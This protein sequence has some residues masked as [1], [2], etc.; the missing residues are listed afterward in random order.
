MSGMQPLDSVTPTH[1]Y[2]HQNCAFTLPNT[3]DTVNLCSNG[4]QLVSKMA[5]ILSHYD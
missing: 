5:S 2:R 1:G 3:Q 4:G